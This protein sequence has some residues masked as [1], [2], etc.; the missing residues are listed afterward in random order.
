MQ[1]KN[2][3]YITVSLL[4]QYT[5]R[6]LANLIK[7]SSSYVDGLISFI[8]TAKFECIWTPPFCALN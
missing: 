4:A 2:I 7:D 8:K 1:Q 3:I 5:K 6:D